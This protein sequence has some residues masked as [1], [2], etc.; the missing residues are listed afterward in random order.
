MATNKHAKK[1]ALKKVG[2]K[3]T[4]LPTKEQIL[5]FVRD[6][7]SFSGKREIARA[8][9]IR[10]A[11]RV[12]L[13]SLLSEMA[14]EGLIDGKRKRISRR[15]QL[16]SVTVIDIV[17]RD[18]DGEFIATPTRWE[19]NY[20]PPRII[21]APS[22]DS[23][24]ASAG[25]GDRVLARLSPL[26]ADDP[27]GAQ[28]EARII[29]KLPREPVQLLGI[30]RANDSGGGVIDP[31]DRKF[32]REWEVSEN[33][34]LTAANGDLVRF[35][36]EKGRGHQRSAA[37]IIE[38]IGNPDAEGA[39]SLIAL[40]SLGLPDEFPE[41]VLK[42]AD[43][44][45]APEAGTFEDLRDVPFIT[46]D[47]ADARDH[48]DAV[49]AT[50]DDDKANPDGWVVWVAIA[51]VSWFI[52]PGGTLDKEA[53]KRGNSVYFPDRVVPML[54]ERISNDLCSLRENEDRS[55]LCMRMTFDAEGNKK[56]HELKRGLMRSRAKLSYAQAQDAFDGNADAKTEPF[57]DDV[58]MPL[59][60]AY[61]TLSK[62]RDK[63]EPLDLNLPE[64][65]IILGDDG[66]VEAV[67]VPPRLEAHRLIEEFMIQANVAAAELLEAKRTPL[68]Y[69][70]HDSPSKE[71][72]IALKEF[73]ST[74]DIS[75]PATGRL[76][77]EH[78]NRILN[79]AKNAEKSELVSE[80][81]LR[82]QA[83]AEYNNN[84]FGHFGLNLKRYAHFT[85]PIRRY[86]D[87]IVHRALIRAFE[88]GPGGLTDGEIEHLDEIAEAISISERRAIAAERQTVDRLIAAFLADRIGAQFPARISGM[89]KSGLFVRLH[90]TGADGFIPAS[91][92]GDDYFR[93]DER[94][95]AMV[96]DRTGARY[97]L[98]DNVE[99]RLIEAIPSAGALRFE[100]LSDGAYR[101][102]TKLRK[103]GG[104]SAT[105]KKGR[106]RASR[107]RQR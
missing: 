72:L 13:K 60:Q 82:S 57:L 54:P 75:V 86:A 79:Q 58:L 105:R 45:A 38:V 51:D 9:G 88:L 35:R 96:G 64:R 18:N 31:I 70:V 53:L 10:G 48:D 69:R 1:K 90:D 5:E 39:A 40:H 93:H 89:V 102:D 59:W 20:P 43:E 34:K 99:V 94:A 6:S 106:N 15:D 36:I 2:R 77:P 4:A 24:G 78:F 95:Q 97:R 27:S 46:I 65:K 63:R 26:E 85:S 104:N 67:T 42:A 33:D 74:L 21:L 81:V 87:L 8:F 25:I 28:Y 66:K 14:D 68:V 52:R 11:D 23:R 84:N 29:K 7:S 107:R 83:Q 61:K 91:T 47:P 55:C 76:K 71:K 3:S 32:L 12:G 62:A 49:W 41:A 19:N 56:G 98:G 16:S 103:R 50:T 17:S 22:N 73:L 100:M 30:Y 37:K 80:V 44:L 92:I 101:T